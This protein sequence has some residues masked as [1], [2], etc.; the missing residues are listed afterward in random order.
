[1]NYLQ[2]YLVDEF[3]EDYQEGHL[4]RRQALKRIAG[5]TGMA[6]AAQILAACGEPATPSD[7]VVQPTDDVTAAQPTAEPAT[8][9]A[10]TSAPTPEAATA[11]PTAEAATAAPTAEAAPTAAASASPDS[12]PADD[13]SITAEMVQFPGSDAQLMG[14][15]ARPSSDG[16]FPI[17]LVCHENRGLTP[18]IQDVTRR[19]AKAGYV[20]LAVDLLSR[21]GGTA[22][23]S[24]QDSIPGLLS[25]APPER[26]VQ[27]FQ[28]GLAYVKQQPFAQPD[29][30][31]MVGFCFGGGVTWLVAANTPELKAAVPFYGPPVPVEQV[32]NINAAVLAIYG[33]Q[34]TRITQT[35]ETME[36][37]MQENGKTFRKVIYPGANHAFH[38]DTGQRYDPE[39]AQAAWQE[40]LAWF[41][42]YLQPA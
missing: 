17:V 9:A 14:Y 28:D 24:D 22:Q 4:S 13:P 23:V 6:V 41:R 11:E 38:N 21:E 26:H 32:P 19:V 42:Q 30:V 16:T 25:G 8:A 36:T 31:G 40:T 18:Y 2:Q 3:V 34:D 20:G 7:A 39:A 10:P 1:M 29:Q 15:M 5:I 12:V 33:E 35:A 27:D 37:A